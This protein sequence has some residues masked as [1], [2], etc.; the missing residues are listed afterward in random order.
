MIII[1]VVFCITRWIHQR[2]YRS[3]TLRL[4]NQRVPQ[5]SNRSMGSMG[6]LLTQPRDEALESMGAQ[7]SSNRPRYPIAPTARLPPPPMPGVGRR[8][9]PLQS[10]SDQLMR[11]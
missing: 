7:S 4:I 9:S 6:N 2:R 3:K 5:P 11:R 8:L 1:G 10:S